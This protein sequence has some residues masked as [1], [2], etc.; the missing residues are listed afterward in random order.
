MVAKRV[1]DR[2]AMGCNTAIIQAVKGS[3][4]P[5]YAKLGFE[6]VSESD[7]SVH[8]MPAY[9]Y[10]PDGRIPITIAVPV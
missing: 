3:S 10:T 4:V 5:I 8:G 7:F 6:T 9:A 2:Q 1:A